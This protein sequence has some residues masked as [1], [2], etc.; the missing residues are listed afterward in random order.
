M[1][2]Y[3]EKDQLRDR[4]RRLADVLDIKD[5]ISMA[6]AIIEEADEIDSCESPHVV[7]DTVRNE[8]LKI[9]GYG[10]VVKAIN[11]MESEFYYA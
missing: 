9:E 6:V 2:T 3:D 10:A 8:L 1:N 11:D 5:R 7:A 4:A